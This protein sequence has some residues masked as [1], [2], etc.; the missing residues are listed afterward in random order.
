MAVF[1]HCTKQ[2]L[3]Q[4]DLQYTV[5]HKGL[6]PKVNLASI[7]SDHKLCRLPVLVLHPVRIDDVVPMVAQLEDPHVATVGGCGIYSKHRSGPLA[8]KPECAVPR[9]QIRG[10]VS[11]ADRALREPSGV[12]ECDHSYKMAAALCA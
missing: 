10:A 6:F 1:Q 7:S 9:L 5:A 12:F 8:S 4:P 2:L 11:G 3:R